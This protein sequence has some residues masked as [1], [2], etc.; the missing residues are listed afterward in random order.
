LNPD[1]IADKSFNGKEALERVIYNVESINNH[2]KC[3]YSLILMDCNMP[4]MDGYESTK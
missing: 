2:K 1:H 4:V 3:S